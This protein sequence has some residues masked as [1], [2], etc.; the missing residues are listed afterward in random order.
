MQTDKKK[1]KPFKCLEEY[2]VVIE[3]IF[4]FCTSM[5]FMYKTTFSPNEHLI[6]IRTCLGC[7]WCRILLIHLTITESKCVII[8]HWDIIDCV[9]L[10]IIW[11]VGLG[12]SLFLVMQAWNFDPPVLILPQIVFLTE[13]IFSKN[14]LLSVPHIFKNTLIYNFI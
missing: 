2:I 3:A 10:S 1:K 9:W 12:W 7:R 8:H 4:S 5:L 13:T 11:H 6:Y 14:Y